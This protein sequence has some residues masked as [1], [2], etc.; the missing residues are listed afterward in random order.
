M[1]FMRRCGRSDDADAR[2]EMR[3][4]RRRRPTPIRFAGCR[5]AARWVRW[6]PPARRWCRGVAASRR[7]PR[8]SPRIKRPNST[9]VFRCLWLATSRRW[10]IPGSARRR[11]ATGP[12]SRLPRS[13]RAS[14]RPGAR[15]RAWP[16]PPTTPTSSGAA[17]WPGSSR[18]WRWPPG[19]WPAPA[20]RSPTK[21]RRGWAC[22]RRPATPRRWTASVRSC[23]SGCPAPA[24]SPNVTR[25]FAAP[26][27]CRRHASK[28]CS[29][30][31]SA[32]AAR[33][34]GR[35]L[36]LPAG[37]QIALRAADERGW[38]AFSRPARRPQLGRLGV[39]RRR[40]R[41]RATAAAGRARRHARPPRA[42]RAGDGVA[43]RGAGLDGAGVDAGLRSAPAA[44][45][46]RR[47]SRRRAAAA[48]RGARARVRRTA[49]ARR[50]A[51]AIG[52]AGGWCAS[53]GWSPPSTSKSRI[54]P[55]TT[56]TPRSAPKRRRRGCATT[57]WCSTRRACCRSS[58]SSAHG[59]V[60]YP[61]GRRLVADAVA[62]APAADRWTRFA[63]I[64]TLLDANPPAGAL[65]AANRE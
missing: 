52:R 62:A 6:P 8:R 4:F 27:P 15:W 59:C 21:R 18:P 65:A 3:D 29:P 32:G 22:G 11:G 40:R 26:R 20:P 48:A 33:P 1:P 30:T 51:A 42:A 9:F 56:S 25:R 53:N 37:E 46:G 63:A 10:S 41:R 45:R 43:G 7:R 38:A 31:R 44:G 19:G 2:S 49:A 58:R 39:A 57:R 14:P 55:P 36:P 34:R 50:R 16:T 5:V 47:R 61:L 54:S 12:G 60:A 64:S 17:T 24:R 23:R 13:S 28:R 35:V